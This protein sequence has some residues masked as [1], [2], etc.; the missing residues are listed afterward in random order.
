[1]Y[2]Y[3]HIYNNI[4]CTNVCIYAIVIH[5]CFIVT[6]T[7]ILIN[8]LLY[9]YISIYILNIYIYIYINMLLL[10]WLFIICTIKCIYIHTI[11]VVVHVHSHYLHLSVQYF[12]LRRSEAIH[13]CGSQPR[14]AVMAHAAT[15]DGWHPHD[16]PKWLVVWNMTFI[17]HFIYPWLG[18]RENLQETMVFTL[19]M[20][21]SCNVNFP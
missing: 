13:S 15:V 7:I 19:N 17:S 2:I 5:I 18:L 12:G 14:G 20:F 1:M 8:H 21:F 10:Y 3:K 16:H 6:I 11:T 9:I 4:V